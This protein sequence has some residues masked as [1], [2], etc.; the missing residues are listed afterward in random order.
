MATVYDVPADA[1][2]ERVAKRLEEIPEI[3]MPEWA[4]F[5]KTGAHKERLPEQPN[6][7]YIRAASILRRIYIDGPVGVARLRTYYGG[8][9][10]RGAK[11]E[12]HVDA[13]GKI[14]R[15]ILQQ[16]EKAGLVEKDGNNGR[17]ISRKGQSLLDK[18][19]TAIVAGK[20]ATEK[21]AEEKKEE[22][23]ETAAAEEKAEKV[24]QKE[25]EE[26][27]KGTKKKAKKAKKE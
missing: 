12:H 14:I 15:T 5:V 11:P 23:K 21:K 2:I 6:W 19:A 8:R 13:S 16:L 4:K 24:E 22:K 9:K 10:N 20:K 3:K 7:W 17:K 25:K 1:L 27:K 18:E 26:E